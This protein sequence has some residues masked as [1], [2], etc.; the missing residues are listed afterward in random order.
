MKHMILTVAL[1]T[2]S[3]STCAHLLPAAE[4]EPATNDTPAKPREL[5][6][7]HWSY[8]LDASLA[9]A[10][11]SDKPVFLLFQEIPGCMTCQRFGDGPLSHPL[12]VEAIEDLFV[13]VAVYNNREGKD[14]VVLKKYNEPAWNN[15]VVRFVGADGKDIIPREDKIW[16]AHGI[17]KRMKAA[18]EAAHKPVPTYLE[19]TIEETAPVKTKTVMIETPCFWNGE[20]RLGS[21]P[22]VTA[23][24]AGF[25]KKHEVVEVTFDPKKVSVNEVIQQGMKMK[26]FSRAYVYDEAERQQAQE[27]AGEK[28]EVAE[29]NFQEAPAK[30]QKYALLQS[31]YRFLDLTPLQMLRVNTALGSRQNPNQWLSPRQLAQLSA[32]KLKHNAEVSARI[33]QKRK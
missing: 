5:G 1:M 27:V 12:L 3:L 19:L 26:C 23:T 22:G 30:D 14:A 9:Q 6:R 25:H 16:E 8:D 4:P 31:A 15:P 10:K 2:M 20:I 24:R 7:V 21:V 29:T 11:E 33:Q 32:A 28:V 18:L 17:A 13:P